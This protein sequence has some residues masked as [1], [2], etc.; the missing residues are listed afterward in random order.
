[1]GF[2]LEYI[3]KYTLLLL[4]PTLFFSWLCPYLPWKLAQFKTCLLMELMMGTGICKSFL[5]GCWGRQERNF[6]LP[7]GFG[8][9]F[10]WVRQDDVVLSGYNSPDFYT[11]I[12]LSDSFIFEGWPDHLTFYYTVISKGECDTVCWEVNEW[13]NEPVSD[14][15]ILVAVGYLLWN[16]KR[17]VVTQAR[18]G[19]WK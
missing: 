1:M 18:F 15:S 17:N 9:S 19:N 6:I 7:L 3:Y 11:D 10:C 16:K 13:Q 5:T 2:R 14:A 4:Y 8:V 12:I